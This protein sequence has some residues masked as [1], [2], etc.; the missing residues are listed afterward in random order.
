MNESKME[1]HKL[2]REKQLKNC[3]LLILANKQV[4]VVQKKIITFQQL[5]FKVSYVNKWILCYIYKI[6]KQ[7][8]KPS[9]TIITYAKISSEFLKLVLIIRI[10]MEQLA[11][12]KLEKN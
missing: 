5:S 12:G 10:C 7:E 6:N 9:L 3:V 8:H 4:R 1:L 2:L 11:A